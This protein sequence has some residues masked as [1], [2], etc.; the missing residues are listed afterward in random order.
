MDSAYDSSDLY[1]YVFENTNCIPVIDT[2]RRRGI[3][4][5]RLSDA[6][7]RGIERILT[8]LKNLSAGIIKGGIMKAYIQNVT[9]K[10]QKRHSGGDCLKKAF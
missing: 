7:R 4:E 10:C 1:E 6:R 3:I 2:N 5:S 9:C 8:R